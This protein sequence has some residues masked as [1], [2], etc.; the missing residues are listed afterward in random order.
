VTTVTVNNGGTFAPGPNGTPGSMSITGPLTFQSGGTY[1]VQ[2][3]PVTASIANV[4]GTGT[5]TG[6]SVTAQFAPGTYIAKSYDILHTAGLGGTTFT[7]VTGNVPRGFL[8]SLSYTTTDVMLDLTGALGTGG[9]PAISAMSRRRSTISSTM[10]ARCRPA[11]SA[12]SVSPA[13]RLPM[14]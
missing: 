10:A 8:A 9:S 11:S 3:T 4:G 6:G 14:R 13:L 5:L 1:Q 2:V 7:G 12:C